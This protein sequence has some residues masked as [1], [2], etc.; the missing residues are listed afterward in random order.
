VG[1]PVA[2]KEKFYRTKESAHIQII[3]LMQFFNK[4]G[5]I[6]QKI[7]NRSNDTTATRTGYCQDE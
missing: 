4:A 2:F 5:T 1:F 7:T 6:S 3:V